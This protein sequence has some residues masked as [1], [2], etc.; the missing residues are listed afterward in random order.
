[1][2]V[3]L[4][5]FS[6]EAG[7]AKTSLNDLYEYME[8]QSGVADTSRTNE[9]R[10]YFSKDADPTYAR[11]LVVT[12]KN[13][14]AFCKLVD[15]KGRLVILVENLQGEDKVM[16]FN[17]FVVNK[18][19]GL[20]IYQQYHH[21]CSLGVFGGYLRERYRTLSTRSI[22]AEILELRRSRQ[23][24]EARERAIRRAHRGNL[25]VATLVHRGNLSSVLRQF[26]K[27]K[28][29]EYEFAQI[30]AIRDVARPLQPYVSKRKEKVTFEPRFAVST[31]ATAVHNAVEMIV[32]KS[33]R[34]HVET[35]EG[36]PLSVKLADIPENFGEYDFDEIATQLDQLDTADFAEHQTF[37][38]LQ[39][40]CNSEPYSHIFNARTRR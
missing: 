21:S 24:S 5:G 11:G 19:N 7:H 13:Q 38:D 20:G 18:S 8:L 40:V 1:M 27:I 31:I 33:G 32:P 9:R 16:E 3:R 22:D 39:D 15:E 4:Y 25:T 14:K 29:F 37:T 26:E 30:E 23:H 35:D 12:V 28:S 36:D 17:F 34:V 6:L 10:I 2:K